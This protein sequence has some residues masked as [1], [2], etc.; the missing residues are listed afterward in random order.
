MEGT[1]TQEW[2]RSRPSPYYNLSCMV[3]HNICIMQ[4]DAISKQLNLGNS[5]DRDREE[6]RKLLECVIAQV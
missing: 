2:E 3:R 5:E 4:G 1:S 6:I